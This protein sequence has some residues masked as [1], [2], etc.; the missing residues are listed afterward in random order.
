[1]RFYSVE[2]G[3][4]GGIGGM[5]YHRARCPTCKVELG[6]VRRQIQHEGRYM[7]DDTRA[8]VE[9]PS[10]CIARRA[11]RRRQCSTPARLPGQ[12]PTLLIIAMPSLLTCPFIVN[13][14]NHDAANEKRPHLPNR[15]TESYDD[16]RRPTSSPRLRRPSFCAL[17]KLDQERVQADNQTHARNR[18]EQ[19]VT[20][21]FLPGWYQTGG[22]RIARPLP[23]AWRSTDPVN[24][25]STASTKQQTR[26]TRTATHAPS[27]IA[28]CAGRRSGSR[29]GD[30]RFDPFMGSGNYRRCAR[31]NLA[32]KFIG[33]DRAQVLRLQSSA[34]DN[35]YRQSM[36]S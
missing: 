23:H 16:Y 3:G 27:R 7:T 34:S 2:G 5:S 11:Y 15:V 12:L 25:G 24:R 19:T 13:L 18:R 6:R 8:G 30:V 17:T 33:I 21:A 26:L 10:G 28:G 22:D 1:M 20:E 4:K 31:A 35:A 9:R 32:A 29:R 36:L 14:G